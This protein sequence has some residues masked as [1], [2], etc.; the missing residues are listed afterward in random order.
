MLWSMVVAF[1]DLR[2]LMWTDPQA[3]LVA[4]VVCSSSIVKHALAG[5]LL[6]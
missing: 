6:M 1:R 4:G 2:L 3:L 5:Q